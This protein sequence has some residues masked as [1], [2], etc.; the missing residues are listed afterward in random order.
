MTQPRF[1]S[2][3]LA[4]HWI[5]DARIEEVAQILADIPGLT[6]WWP[7]VYLAAELLA[8][9]D[10]VTGLGRRFAVHSRGFLPYTLRWRGEVVES[11]APRCWTIAAEGDLAGRGTWTLAQVG[12]FADIRYDWQVTVE[13]PLL[14]RLAPLLRPAYAANHRWAMARGLE[15]LRRE[16]AARRGAGSTLDPAGASLEA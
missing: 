11:D 15:G 10:P 16:I 14:S 12:R 4:S 13:Q 8:P 3:R 1:D 6:R 9:G 5:L 7:D 2:F